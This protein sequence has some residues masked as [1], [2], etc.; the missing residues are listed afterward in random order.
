MKEVM[1]AFREFASKVEVIAQT[2]ALKNISPEE[3][4]AL[5]ECLSQTVKPDKPIL[6]QSA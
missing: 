3:T 6:L 1:M 4:E 2:G 5:L